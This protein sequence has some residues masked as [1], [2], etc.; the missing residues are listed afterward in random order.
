MTTYNKNLGFSARLFITIAVVL[1]VAGISLAQELQRVKP[2][3]VGMS[4]QKLNELSSTLDAYARNGRV[5]GGVAMVLRRGKVAYVHPFGSRDR[6][7]RSPMNEDAIFRIA[8]QSKAITSVAIMIL[9]ED[10]KLLLNDPVGKYIPEFANTTVAAPKQGG[11][12]DIVKSKRP[13]TIRD[14]LTHTAGIGYGGGPGKDKWEAAGIT[15][16][17]F[18]DRD[19]PIGETV[20]RMAS[21]PMDAQPG[22]AFVY[23]YNTDILGVVIERASGMPLDQFLTTRILAPLDMKDTSFYL[24]PTKAGRLTAVYSL[25]NGKLERAPDAGRVGQG[26]YLTGPRK[27]FSGGAG[28][29]STARDYGRFLQMLANGGQLGGKRILSRKSVELMTVDHLRGIPFDAGEGFGLG[30]SIV[31]DVGAYGSLSSVGEFGWGG[32][33]HTNYW[34]DPKEQ[35]VV[36]YFTQL[37]PAAGIDDTAK[38]RAMV[39]A[40]IVD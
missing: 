6:E 9:Q 26:A 15:G 33:Y 23:G 30:F 7:A 27:S 16:W 13:I 31:K 17:Y 32:A 29:L 1:S 24:P 5:A 8:S 37:I 14:L 39:Y 36:L 35:M 21:L 20:K 12:Y 25:T 4:S 40:S 10:G 18:A 11:G 22:T 38:L 19:E 3:S 28:L 2:E 34:V